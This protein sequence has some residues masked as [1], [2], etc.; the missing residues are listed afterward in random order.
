MKRFDYFEG[1]ELIKG[2][3]DIDA[4]MKLTKPTIFRV[5][6]KNCAKT[7]LVSSLIHGCEPCGFRAIL[8]EINSNP[9][10][11]FDVFFLIGNVKAAQK[12]P[13]F[14]H[15]LL[16]DG[17]NYNR[18]WVDNPKTEDE[19]TAAEILEFLKTL[20]LK[21]TLD[22]HS[23]TAETQ[24]PHAFI[25]SK[26]PGTINLA[27]KLVPKAFLT[28]YRVGAMIE[29]LSPALVVEC[30]TNNSKEADEFAFNALQTFFKEVG[31]KPGKNKDI[32]DGFFSNM[33]NI[34]IKPGAS[35]V[36]SDK[37]QDADITMREDAEL[38]NHKE[39]KAGEFLAYTD[40]LDHFKVT[41]KGKEIN[42][43]EVL[44]LKDGKVF[45]KK[46]VFPNLIAKKE[47]IAKE[48]GFYFFERIDV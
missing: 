1:V 28:D 38:L 32:C 34:K 10:Y 11:P 2:L 25:A 6:G 17:Q 40:S 45:T 22:L 37:K 23:F 16:P 48:S 5:K 14:T 29:N 39:I 12:D 15:R 43:S 21:G 31:I 46:K 24:D 7:V 47:K 18:I 35:I 27:R 26:D 9:E 44:E 3:S 4:I 33:T 42:P 13:V 19:K 8:K 20:S 30:G 41:Q 36:W